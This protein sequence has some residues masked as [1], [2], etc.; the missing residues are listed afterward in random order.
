LVAVRGNREVGRIGAADHVDVAGRRI[1]SEAQSDV[2]HSRPAEQGREHQL[3]IRRYGSV[4]FG[5]EGSNRDAFA[6]DRDAGAVVGRLAIV[7]TVREGAGV[8]GFLGRGR[9]REAGH[10]HF[11]TVLRHGTDRVANTQ[12]ATDNLDAKSGAAEVGRIVDLAESGS[13]ARC[14]LSDKSRGR[15]RTR[16]RVGFVGGLEGSRADRKIGR[17]GQAPDPYIRPVEHDRSANVADRDIDTKGLVRASMLPATGISTF[18]FITRSGF[19]P[20]HSQA[21]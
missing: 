10:V 6:V 15:R 4:Q 17:S 1:E 5:H 11:S 14:Q 20:K 3:I 19:P 12:I 8:R 21:C 2:S 18:T 13:A 16:H 7:G 9:G